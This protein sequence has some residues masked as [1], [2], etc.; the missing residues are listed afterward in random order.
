MRLTLCIRPMGQNSKWQLLLDAKY[1]MQ[2][3]LYK[4]SN[5]LTFF[6]IYKLVCELKMDSKFGRGLTSCSWNN[7]DMSIAFMYNCQ[8]CTFCLKLTERK[9]K[10]LL[11]SESPWWERVQFYLGY[12]WTVVKIRLSKCDKQMSSMLLT[13]DDINWLS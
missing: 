2:W 11:A 9:R 10:L 4:W 12:W 7:M 5:T 1:I 13:P 8:T 6:K 3:H